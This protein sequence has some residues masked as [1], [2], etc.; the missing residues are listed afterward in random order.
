MDALA[1]RA[2][3]RTSPTKR[4]RRTKAE[5][6]RIRGALY[7]LAAGMQPMTVRQVI[8]SARVAGHGR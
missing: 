6:D 4:D 7:D 3:Y 8:L 2:P 1:L 5:I